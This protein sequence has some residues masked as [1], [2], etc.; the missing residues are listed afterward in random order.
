MADRTRNI[1]KDGTAN[2]RAKRRRHEIDGA[3]LLDRVH[4]HLREFI[5]PPTPYALDAITLWIAHAHL[6]DAWE[7]T[8]RLLVT[9]AEPGS[10]KTRV[11]ELV[12]V[13]SPRA[14]EAVNV[15]PSYLFRKV[16]DEDGRPTIC[17]DEIDTVFGPKAKDNEEIRG[18]LN[19]G[20][21]RGAQTGRCVVRGKTVETEEIEAY[22]AVAMAGV[23][24]FTPDTIVSRSVQIRQRRRAPGERVS[25]Y[26]R[27]L[28]EAEGI[29]LREELA[30][31]AA[32]VEGLC[33]SAYPSLPPEIVDRDADVWEPLIAVAD[34]AG[35]EWARRA[36]VAAVALVAETKRKAPS[37][38]VRLLADLQK[39]FGDADQVSTEVIL[40]ELREMDEAPWSDLR[41]KPIDARGLSRLLGDYDIKSTTIRM[42][43]S[44][45]K[46]YRRV[47]LHDAWQRYL[48]ELPQEPATSATAATAAPE[49]DGFDD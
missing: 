11:L 25:P 26:R 34:A 40:M 37:L 28:H 15:T 3:E 38:G 6:M 33:K 46:G 12:A 8:P 4:A 30:S 17:F 47:D 5:A 20:H 16:G 48:C 13:L 43:T 39:V 9:S 36:R 29:A 49:D 7:T 45:P 23:G 44:T 1:L 41:G 14:V 10:G 2:S 22:C 42:G 32:Q 35:L 18:L 31:W 21:R 27:R 24:N 19:A